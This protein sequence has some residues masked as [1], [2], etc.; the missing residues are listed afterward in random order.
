MGCR[1]LHLNFSAWL[2]RSHCLSI[3]FENLT[4]IHPNLRQGNPSLPKTDPDNIFNKLVLHDRGGWCL[5][6]NGLLAWMLESLGF[7]VYEGLARV[8][9]DAVARPSNNFHGIVSSQNPGRTH[10]LTHRTHRIIFAEF[11]GETWLCDVGYGGMGMME[12]VLV[13]AYDDLPST[14]SSSWGSSSS[15]NNAPFITNTTNSSSSNNRSSAPNSSSSNI[16]AHGFDSPFISHQ[17]GT[18][19]RIRYGIRS[20]SQ[21]LPA[22]KALTHPEARSH[23]GYYLQCLVKGHWVDIYYFDLAAATQEDFE[24]EN[25]HLAH[26]HPL[27][28]KQAVVT[29]PTE[30]GR[31]TLVDYDLKI[32]RKGEPVQIVQLRSDG[33][34]DEA[35]WEHFGIDVTAN[36]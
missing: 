8:V 7:N 24:A 32:R 4:L 2:S 11:D 6:M 23:V 28:S 16:D 36:V 5:E 19:Y 20:S 31:S 27:F 17:G 15:S 13:R 1:A 35:L 34:R 14:I 33:E 26:H 29:M 9:K 3:P 25:F 12:P 18:S 21:L 30:E 10:A 22:S